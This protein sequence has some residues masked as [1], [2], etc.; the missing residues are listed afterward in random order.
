MDEF[1]LLTDQFNNLSSIE[2]SNRQKMNDLDL[3]TSFDKSAQK[4]INEK[5][6]GLEI[7]YEILKHYETSSLTGDNVKN[8]FDEII[9]Y[10]LKKKSVELEN[11]Q[12]EIK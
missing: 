10:M 2:I 8:V 6:E 1:E 4:D 11:K 12:S 7:E 5:L 9:N 3:D